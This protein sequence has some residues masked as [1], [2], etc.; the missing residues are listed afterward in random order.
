MNLDKRIV[1]AIQE[2]VKE[3]G[4]SP[5]LAQKMIAWVESLAEGNARLDD[6]DATHRQVELLYQEVVG[7]AEE[8]DAEG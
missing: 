3:M 4:E 1:A 2:A 8:A 7:V 5:A 6:R